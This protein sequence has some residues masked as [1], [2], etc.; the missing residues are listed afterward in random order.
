MCS[1][2]DRCTATRNDRCYLY[3]PTPPVQLC[4]CGRQPLIRK[5]MSA[6]RHYNDSKIIWRKYFT[7]IKIINVSPPKMCIQNAL[8]ND[9]LMFCIIAL[10]VSIQDYYFLSTSQLMS[11][12]FIIVLYLPSKAANAFRADSAAN[13]Y[14]KPLRSFIQ[15]ISDKWLAS[16]LFCW[17]EAV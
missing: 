15:I 9:R 11:L 1:L 14:E 8:V 17:G 13:P 5:M 2:F 3:E 7:C 12:F 6:Y 10:P 4:L 16:K